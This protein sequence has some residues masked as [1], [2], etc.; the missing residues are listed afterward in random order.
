[1]QNLLDQFYTQPEVARRCWHTLMRV[2]KQ[3]QLDLA[4][5]WFIEPS[6]GCGCFY[7]LLPPRRRIGLDI[8]PHKLPQINHRG[9]KRADYLQWLPPNVKTPRKY[10]VV[11]N[12]PFG[13]R[14]ALALSFINKSQPYADMVAFILPQLFASDGKGVA[15]KRVKGYMRAH[16]EQLSGDSFLNQRGE[17]IVVNT[18]FQVWNKVNTHLISHQPQ[19]TCAH[20]ASIV[21]LSDGGTPSSTRNKNMIGKCD[22]YLPSTC[23]NGMR[24]YKSFAELPNQRGYGVLIHRNKKEIKKLLTNNDWYNSAFKSTNSALNLRRSL[25]AKVVTDG[26]YYDQQVY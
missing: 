26:G 14:G 8:A 22:M 11:G 17:P 4:K 9:I 16:T 7:Q 20:Y 15:G 21:S 10:I 25:I 13:V 2:A 24:A 18:I 1:M 5:Y 23:F 12:P 3:L 6:A 19:L